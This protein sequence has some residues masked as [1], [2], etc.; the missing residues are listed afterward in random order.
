MN[1]EKHRPA[2]GKNAGES[3]SIYC[4]T[5]LQK[6]LTGQYIAQEKNKTR[7]STKGTEKNVEKKLHDQAIY[8]LYKKNE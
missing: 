2:K 1:D 6:I 3:S 8:Y 7:T 5:R 4:E